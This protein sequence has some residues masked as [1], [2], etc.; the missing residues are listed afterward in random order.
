MIIRTDTVGQDSDQPTLCNGCFSLPGTKRM[1]AV[2]DKMYPL[3]RLVLFSPLNA[4]NSP[5]NHL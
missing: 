5:L 2:D 3:F 4:A 1:A